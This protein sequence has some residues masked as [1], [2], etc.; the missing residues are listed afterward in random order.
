M[1]RQDN[2]ASP[3]AFLDKINVMS[4]EEL[5]HQ[6]P[7]AQNSLE[8][9]EVEL[10]ELM[11]IR[12]VQRNPR[13]GDE[14]KTCY[15]TA[16]LSLGYKREFFSLPALFHRRAEPDVM[17]L[18]PRWAVEGVGVTESHQLSCCF[19]WSMFCRVL[20]PSS[21]LG[22]RRPTLPLLQR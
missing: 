11:A 22:C 16:S 15:S 6:L 3:G 18:Y 8:A 5:E 20:L 2:G 1:L 13:S 7:L 14:G 19:C 21:T 17:L 9:I 4:L 12:D 10:E